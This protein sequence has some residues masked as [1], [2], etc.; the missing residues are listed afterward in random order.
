MADLITLEDVRIEGEIETD[1]LDARIL[2]KIESVMDAAEAYCA[3]KF[4]LSTFTEH[5]DIEG[6]PSFFYVDNPPWVSITSLAHNVQDASVTID[7]DEDVI[8]EQEYKD[9]GKIQLFN[10]ESVF[11]AGKAS[12]KIVYSGGWDEE[13]FPQDLKDALLQQIL[14]ELNHAERVGIKLQAADGVSVSYDEASGFASQVKVVLDRYKRW[15][16]LI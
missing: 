9:A 5:H 11:Y 2:R 14:F 7:A 6:A 15:D 13:T 8:D 3:R 1:Q 12:A 10:G 4:E 16:K